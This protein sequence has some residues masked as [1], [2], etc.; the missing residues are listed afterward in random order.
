MRARARE[1]EISHV[2]RRGAGGRVKEEGE[3]KRR[4][5]SD[6]TRRGA[7]AD[8]DGRRER[9]LTRVSA[10]ERARFARDSIPHPRW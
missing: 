3:E 2:R 8:G 4:R 7:A 9:K 1:E 6:A 10:L 5:R